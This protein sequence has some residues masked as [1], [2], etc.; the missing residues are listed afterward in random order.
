MVK[1]NDPF[2]EMA[3]RIDESS[4]GIVGMEGLY[5][6]VIENLVEEAGLAY[7]RCLGSDVD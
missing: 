1:I 6:D 5:E 7:H 2:I 4:A 3:K